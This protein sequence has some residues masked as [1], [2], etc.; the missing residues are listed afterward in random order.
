VR[1]FRITP[2]RSDFCL[3]DFGKL[4]NRSLLPH[5]VSVGLM[6]SFTET[7]STS[8]LKLE[9]GSRV[10]VI[11]GGPAGSFFSYFLLDLASRLDVS[12]TV[13]VYEPRDFTAIGAGGCNMCGG[14][15]SESL[16]QSLATEGINLPTTIVE[17]GIDS[18]V[19]HMKE[20][21]AR[22]ATPLEEQRIA[23]VHRGA[24]P[25]GTV[26]S[27]WSSF[28][29]FLLKKAADLGANV[30]RARVEKTE[31]SGD[32]P[33]LLVKGELTE[34]YDMV[35]VATGV[36]SSFLKTFDTAKHEFRPP[37]TSR[38]YISEF[39]LGE[40][41]M[42]E[43]LG[44]AM[45]VFLLDIPRLEFA[46]LI[47]KGDYATLCLLGE[48]IDAALVKALI[49]S[50]EVRSCLPKGWEPPKDHCHCG[51][52][53]SVA[54]AKTPYADRLVF[55]GDAGSTRLYKD[56]INAAYRTS[57]AAAS[58]ALLYG[59][60]AEDFKA[61]FYPVCRDIQRDNAFG[62]F[63]FW[64]TRLQ[65]KNVH[66]RLGI[67]RMVIREQATHGRPRRMS[68]IMWGMFTGSETYRNLFLLSANPFFLFGLAW[69]VIAATCAH[70]WRKK[71]NQPVELAPVRSAAATE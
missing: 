43:C 48:N 39:L 9:D 49:D 69:H 56:G 60:G 33:Q 19:L 45:H 63:I 17:R 7:R 5:Y 66:D 65:Q 16:V 21:T 41:V 50:D 57:K 54:A 37:K 40:E 1:C 25:K 35:A 13:D 15:I 27:R 67:L 52:Q 2:I 47:P 38:T 59:V 34:P 42:N 32:K 61:H 10:A 8:S 70:W 18:Y 11:G 51:P 12:I 24:G 55:L 44:N 20:G 64:I 23:A 58:A 3:C 14:I 22:I 53:I 46:A 31:W 68:S 4:F 26:N 28:D 36:N 29:G 30:H 71:R 6:E 62:K